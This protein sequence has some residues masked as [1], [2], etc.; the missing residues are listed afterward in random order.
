MALDDVP[1]FSP[2]LFSIYIDDVIH[3]LRNFG[4]GLHVGTNF[5]GCILYADDIVL[6]SC[7][8]HGIQQLVDICLKY[9][10]KCDITFNSCKT[11]RIT[12]GGN[13]PV[14]LHLTMNHFKLECMGQY[15]KISRMS[16]PG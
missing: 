11:Q 6:L 9:G 1:V 10:K 4:F 5:I 13:N 8:C 15:L 2:I 14:S 3:N 16:L 12:F 7:S